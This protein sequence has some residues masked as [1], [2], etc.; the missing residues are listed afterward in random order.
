METSKRNPH[1]SVGTQTYQREEPETPDRGEAEM[2]K[3]EGRLISW[4][5]GVK[6]DKKKQSPLKAIRKTRMGMTQGAGESESPFVASTRTRLHRTSARD[7]KGK[8][9]EHLGDGPEGERG[10]SPFC[11]GGQGIKVK[12]ERSD[13]GG[14]DETPNKPRPRERCRHEERSDRLHNPI[15]KSG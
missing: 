1:E 11:I 4:K 3:T 8:I 14:N 12:E 10:S 7:T 13:K 9:V 5:Y 6:E 15:K 2:K